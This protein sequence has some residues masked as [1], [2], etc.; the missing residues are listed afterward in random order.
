[1][2]AFAGLALLLA[3]VGLY[4]VMALTVTQRTRELGIR[5]AIGVGCGL[6]G[7]LAAGRALTSV[8]YGVGAGRLHRA[9]R[10]DN[11]A[12]NRSTDHLLRAARRATRVDPMIALR[13]E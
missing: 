12:H 11:V 5:I 10:S 1:M 13:D 4:G 8:L 7:A 3:S 9:R 6:L 2:S